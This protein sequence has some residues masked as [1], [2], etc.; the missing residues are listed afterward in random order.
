M[1]RPIGV[2]PAEYTPGAWTGKSH[3]H[4]FTPKPTE[5]SPFKTKGAR[6]PQPKPTPLRTYKTHDKK[7]YDKQ[8]AAARRAARTPEQKL[9]AREYHK[10]Y[11]RRRREQETATR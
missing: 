3:A 7:A 1:L 2:G 10:E 4:L 9:A 11:M 5:L 6:E 8:Y